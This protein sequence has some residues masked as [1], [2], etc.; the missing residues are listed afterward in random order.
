MKFVVK[1]KGV[2]QD[3]HHHPYNTTRGVYEA[4]FQFKALLLANWCFV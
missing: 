3:R 4:A 2:L 1:L